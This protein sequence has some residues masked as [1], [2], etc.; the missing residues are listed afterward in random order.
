MIAVANSKFEDKPTTILWI[1]NLDD[2][3]SLFDFTADHC[4]FFSFIKNSNK[5]WNSI[6]EK[7]KRKFITKTTICCPRL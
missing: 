2:L 4:Y 3:S 7:N 6:N 1:Q 5:R